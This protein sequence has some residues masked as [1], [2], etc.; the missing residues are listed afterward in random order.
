MT[1]LWATIATFFTA[2]TVLL[3]STANTATAAPPPNFQTSLIIGSGLNGPS[4]FGIAPDDR[5]F[6]LQRTGEVLIYKNGQLLPEP[7][8]VLPSAASGDRGLIGVAFDPAFPTNHYV[9][10][11]YTAVGD[12]LNYLVRFDASQDTAFEDPFILYQTSSPSQEL[13]VGGSIQFGPDGKLYFAIGD[14]GNPPNA[15]NLNNPHGKILR[16][17]PDGTVPPDNPFTT[18]S[19]ALPEIW[20]YGLRNPWRFQ[21]DPLTGL[22]IGGDVGDF[23][24]EEVNHLIKGG[25]YGWP[26]QEGLCTT[27]CTGYL[28]PL[29]T[30]NHDGLSSA[31]TG[32][33]FYRGSMFPAEYYGDYFFGD[34]AR[35]FI[36]RLELDYD[37]HNPGEY[38]LHLLDA[39]T[40][41]DNAGSVVDLQVAP[42]GSLYYI[43]YYP[44]RLYRISYSEDNHLPVANAG[45]D[46]T[47]GTSPFTVNFTSAGS[48]DPDDD[49]ISFLWDF[50]DGTTST[51]ANPTHVFTQNG[52]YLV[53]LT[54]SDDQGHSANA[55]PITIQVG[56]PPNLTISSPVDGSTFVAGDTILVNSHA[57]DGVG[58][59]ISDGN[60]STEIIFHHDT[61]IHPFYGPAAGRAHQAT[62]P[63]TGEPDPDTWFEI[64]VTA[65]DTNGLSTTETVNIYPELSA[66]TI[67]TVPTG[68]T[69][70]LDGIPIT[71]PDT[72]SSVVNFQ[73]QLEAPLSQTLNDQTYQFSHWSTGQPRIHTFTNP[74]TD[75]NHVAHYLPLNAFT[76]QY[77]DNH[78]LTGSP[79]LSRSDPTIDFNWGGSSPD[80][81]IPADL[82]SARWTVTQAFT[83]GT[84]RFT[85]TT[86]DG[87][88]LYIDSQ[89]IIDQWIDQSATSHT[90]QIDLADDDHQI[91]MEYYER[92]GGAVAQLTWELISPA[93]TPTPTGTAT[94]TPSEA[95]SGA[96]AQYWN[97][98]GTGASPDFPT[99]PPDAT[100]ELTTINFDWGSGSPHPDIAADHFAA[101]FTQPIHFQA[102]PYRF[103][104]DAD[105]GIRLYL[106]GKLFLDQWI[107]QPPTRY[108]YDLSN[109]TEADHLLTVE[110]YEN[111]GGAL[112]QV[113]WEQLIETT[114]TPTPDSGTGYLAE[115]WNLPFPG[116][117]PSIPATQADLI[118][119]DPQVNHTWG[120]GSPDPVINPD[121]F[122]ARWTRTLE[123]EAG[124]YQFATTAD[125]GV[126]LLIDGQPFIDQWHDQSVTQYSVQT[127]L[128]AGQHQIVV[129][130][131]ENG[132]DAVILFDY[133]LLTPEP[134]PTPTEQPTPISTPTP[135][136]APSPTPTP[137]ESPTPT[138]TEQPTPSP[139]PTTPPTDTFTGHYWNV[140]GADSQP[141]IPTTPPD[142]IRDDALI[143]FTWGLTSPDPLIN[144]DHF[145]ARWTHTLELEAGTYR[146]TTDSDD[147]IRAYVD[148]QLIIDQWNDHSTTHHTADLQLTT[149]SH[150]IIVEY[151]ENAYDAVAKFSWIHLP[152]PPTGDDGYL[153]EFW[154]MPI[155]WTTP[156]F[157]TYPAELSRL[158]PQINI[159]W[160]YD[161]PGSPIE[162]DHFLARWT[163]TIEFEAA[164]YRFT[165]ESD[166]GAR[167]YLDGQLI[168]D[169]WTDHA[170]TGYTAEVPITAGSHQIVI[171]Y[172]DRTEHATIFFTYQSI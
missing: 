14:N 32:G 76:G 49:P 142:L 3:A 88:R 161:S 74:T 25:N 97:L 31:V 170:L 60:Y 47:K 40:F 162:P 148:S 105:D 1:K 118:R 33:P 62:I 151:Y 96:S 131:Y 166:D 101:R 35:G 68:L 82:F 10:F 106:D 163:R 50:G 160:V 144:P 6:I 138:P 70:L 172:Y 116:G 16:I 122:I 140:P 133:Q 21:F 98:P 158:D 59:D 78:N 30:Y 34:Y 159:N 52:T 168:I 44:G 9:Y 66:Y 43:T 22:L 153:A 51:A 167:L 171:E 115:F 55:I 57:T 77:F 112:A 147:G 125:D 56:I 13:H 120:Y 132:Y 83:A 92:Y 93:P 150:S 104:I 152:D 102:T 73:R 107:D 99:T 71:T 11:Y 123:L 81:T 169:A 154:N 20:A 46:N 108:I 8:A 110:Y 145:I 165:L 79:V 41:D 17:N 119:V 90:G 85:T 84:Y 24:W 69:I 139:T 39:Q 12:L 100:T 67:D 37:E 141:V 64:K 121:G 91:I 45:A 137:T 156:T 75:S 111:T 130:Y 72:R 103:T 15:Q 5:I 117:A 157:P 28:D 114:P 36:R 113:S 127:D 53:E 89:L 61:H 155:H 42:D 134:T 4:G 143:N 23:T 124:T 65:T 164:T 109:N 38:H 94:P 146:F 87:V 54:V 2:I 27:G 63:T 48:Y 95:P 128:T 135:T 7:F 86:D 80:P 129:E 58:N 149:G 29:Y 126:R 136:E 26:V 19:G 18:I